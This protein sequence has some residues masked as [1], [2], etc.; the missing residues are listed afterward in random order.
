MTQNYRETQISKLVLFE[1]IDASC[2]LIYTRQKKKK[3]K[4]KKKKAYST[5]CKT[6]TN[7]ELSIG[8]SFL[9]KISCNFCQ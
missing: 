4:K 2:A 6:I 7:Y 8:Y 3:K 5:D 9:S 1:S